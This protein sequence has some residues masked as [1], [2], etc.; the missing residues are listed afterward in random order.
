ME[1][2]YALAA[3]DRSTLYGGAYG[4]IHASS[5]DSRILSVMDFVVLRLTQMLQT[6]SK[7]KTSSLRL[8]TGSY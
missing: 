2:H 7:C 3:V 1:I 4:L 8:G 6:R 5:A